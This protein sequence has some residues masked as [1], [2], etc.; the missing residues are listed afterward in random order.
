MKFDP[1]N[2]LQ[3][4]NY[5]DNHKGVNPA[6]TDSSTFTFDKAQDMLDTFEGK[7]D[8]LF[9]YSRHTS[10]SGQF[11]SDALAAMEG[12]ESAHVT[13]SGMGA[14]TPTILQLCN[15]GDEI[16][17]S[18]TIYG[19]THAFL[20]NYLPKFNI[21][22]K[23]VSPTDVKEIENAINNNT[24]L[25]YI[26]SISNP[27]LEVADIP[28]ISAIAKKHNIKLVIDNTFSPMVLSPIRLGADIV[29]YSLTKYING[30]SDTLGGAICG[31]TEFINS[32][33]SLNDGSSMLLGSVL[34][35]IRASSI[36]KNLRTLHLRMK[37]HSNNAMYLSRKF[38][39]IGIKVSYP[40]LASH[41][42]NH[43][44]TKLKN[45]GFGYSGMFTIDVG[46][47]EKANLLME[48]MQKVNI[49]LLAV[50]LGFYKTL[51]SAP[52]TSTSS[53]ISIKEQHKIGIGKGLIRFSI[54]LD[55]DIERTFQNIKSCMVS[56]G[57]L[58]NYS[59]NKN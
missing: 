17:A 21:H 41:P 3:D 6:I 33:K 56:T 35:P 8:G 51:F 38:E 30:A 12:S 39:E 18:R 52:G 22:T 34:D 46:S 40:G 53:E 11:L 32:L 16:I 50:S 9:L 26:E 42:Q 31:S 10:P 43:L 4:L 2:N 13:A 59:A 47:L 14:I 1:A 58:N 24:K 27:L 5:S 29:V 55:H 36:T 19:G 25:I 23:F 54:G 49:G 57:I 20:Q 7:S 37:Q 45:E 15:S 28:T 44:I 48:T